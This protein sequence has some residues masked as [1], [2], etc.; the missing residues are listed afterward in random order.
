MIKRSSLT[1]SIVLITALLAL[2][3]ALL[4]I[5]II[6]Q[7]IEKHWALLTIGTVFF[8]LILLGLIV[9]FIWT[10]REYRLNRRQANFIDS[11]THELK[12]P[13]ASIKLCLQT[14]DLRAVSPEQQQEFHKFM[15]EDIQRLDSLID[16]LLAV[17]RLDH[18]DREGELE[19]VRLDELLARCADEVKRRYD[20]AADRIR[21]ETQP[22]AV[23]G[24]ARDLETVFL[25]LLDNAVKYGGEEPKVL[26]QAQTYRG[27]RAVAKIS[28]NGKGVT[29][30]LRR[31]IFQ[32]FYRG[33]SELERTTK[34][35]GL[36]LYIVKS[37]VG[38]MKGKIYVHGRGAL[39]GATFE[40]DLP[41]QSLAPEAVSVPP[42][43]DVPAAGA[44]T[45][46]TAGSP[47]ASS[48]ADEEPATHAR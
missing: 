42:V 31:K 43:R 17:A 39:G 12:S 29:F 14:L 23:R 33:G 15:L 21:L 40:V 45:D 25:N 22:V 38:K 9:Y 24:L 3:V 5:W 27:S 36:G 11:V 41:G 20:L 26:V 34:G 4:V 47:T 37:L 46:E 30:E 6:A 19:T 13:I 48:A 2:I 7:A 16:H 28:D 32:R 18:G 35:T 10:I 44:C 1:W 8:A